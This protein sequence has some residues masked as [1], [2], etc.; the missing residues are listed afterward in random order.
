MVAKN[1][2]KRVPYRSPPSIVA[3]TKLHASRSRKDF[4]PPYRAAL[5]QQYSVDSFATLRVLSC[6]HWP[7][8]RCSCCNVERLCCDLEAY[9]LM[10]ASTG[11]RCRILGSTFHVRLSGAMLLLP[12]A[13]KIAVRPNTETEIEELLRWTDHSTSEVSL[14]ISETSVE[15]HRTLQSG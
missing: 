9:T 4:T 2:P 10:T 1:C 15:V 14:G 11:P 5:S 13:I 8:L 6:V 12:F 7:G 3:V